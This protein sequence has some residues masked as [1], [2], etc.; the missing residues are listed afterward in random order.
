MSNHDKSEDRFSH[1]IDPRTGYPVDP[2]H[3]FNR[4][5]ETTPLY[6]RDLLCM[7][8]AFEFWDIKLAAVEAM[9]ICR[10]FEVEWP[11][12]VQKAAVEY[13]LA[14]FFDESFL[15]SAG[16]TGNP[17]AQLKNE[18]VHWARWQEVDYTRTELQP[19]V[20]KYRRLLKEHEHNP[21]MLAEI[22]RYPPPDV[23]T[24]KQDSYEAASRELRGTF[25]Q[26][27]PGTIERSYEKVE[28]GG[29]RVRFFELEAIARR[30]MCRGKK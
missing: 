2:N 11:E 25:A 6:V 20:V 24:T 23:G 1:E 10:K 27:S 22:V 3:P 15:K 12:W 30:H 18:M 19:R 9:L 17:G 29:I 28:R 5:R 14:A 16:C 21:E 8:E 13:S 26:G 7:R 4:P